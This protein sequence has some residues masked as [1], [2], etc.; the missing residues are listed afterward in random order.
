M[1]KG[2]EII[3]ERE[4]A[5]PLGEGEYYIEDLKNL[6]VIDTEGKT[7]G[8]LK[9]IIEGGGGYLAELKL[10]SGIERLV[11][12]RKEFFGEVNLNERIIYLLESWILE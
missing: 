1:L 11:P 2:A 5:A 6:S 9:N 4:Y 3:A 8:Y 7:I 12:F 10:H